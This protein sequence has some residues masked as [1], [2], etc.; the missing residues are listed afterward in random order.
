LGASYISNI[1]KRG[2]GTEQVNTTTKYLMKISVK[3]RHSP[4]EEPLDRF[5]DVNHTMVRLLVEGA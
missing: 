4:L 2:I 1:I 3:Y 5:L